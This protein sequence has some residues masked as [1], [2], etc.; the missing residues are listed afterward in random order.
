MSYK[1]NYRER[2]AVPYSGSVS[3]S[4]PPSE[5]GGSGSVRY[6]GTAYEDV[7][8]NI[9]L[10][11][12]EFDDSVDDCNDNVNLLTGAVIA[13]EAAQIASIHKNS[14]RIA[15][16]IVDGFFAYIRSE[17]SQQI[18]E[19]MQSI[20]SQL[21][22][23]RELSKAVVDKKQQMEGDFLRISS[24]Y[25][26]TFNSLNSELSNR[27]FELDKAA[28]TFRKELD[29]QF[30]RT[31]N[32]DLVNT[33]AIFGRES[34]ELQSRISASIAKKR[35]LDT[36]S[37]VKVFL[38][39]QKKLNDVVR[40]SMLTENFESTHFSSVCFFQTKEDKGQISKVIYT[41]PIVAS[42]FFN[43]SKNE[44]IEQFSDASI[45]WS[46]IQNDHLD[47]IYFH[48]NSELNTALPNTDKHSLRVKQVIQK[49]ANLGSIQVLSIPDPKF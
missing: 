40:D 37:R 24:R 32:N 18:T 29:K 15:K 16:T 27:I 4:Y 48:F 41:P 7:N 9:I 36:I 49:I 22:H 45:S 35:S 6:S 19:L 11:T 3:Y 25:I 42:L 8:I 33:V 13:T 21:M 38:S 17:I 1:R 23:L 31:S 12:E 28:F 2:L 26:K 20:E 5:K 34:G 14:G 39:Q 30:V 44:L 46:A 47:K 43:H 10:D